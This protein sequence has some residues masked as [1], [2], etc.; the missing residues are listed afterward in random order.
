MKMKIEQDQ[1]RHQRHSV[2]VI[3]AFETFQQRTKQSNDI[4][5]SSVRN[6]SITAEVEQIW[7]G[8]LHFICLKRDPG[9]L[10]FPHFSPIIMKCKA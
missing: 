5:K 7:I 4:F 8:K 10:L 9:D 2:M 6:V 3:E 1:T